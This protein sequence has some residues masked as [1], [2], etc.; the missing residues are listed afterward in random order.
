MTL[1]E[2]GADVGVGNR[3]GET[4]LSLATRKKRVAVVRL[5]DEESSWHEAVRQDIVEAY[6]C[7]QQ[8][9]EKSSKH[10]RTAETEIARLAQ[11]AALDTAQSLDSI[12]GWQ[13]C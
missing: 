2:A 10:F 11:Q 1:L 7:Y 13:G 12:T 6:R 8:R 9:Y 4:A 3:K 5:L